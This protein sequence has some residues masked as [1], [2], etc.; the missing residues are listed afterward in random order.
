MKA[1]VKLADVPREAQVLLWTA[2][3]MTRLAKAGAISY[4][5]AEIGVD[6]LQVV[7]DL[8]SVKPTPAELL[9]ACRE[10]LGP[11][12]DPIVGT[13]NFYVYGLLCAVL[14]V[15]DVME[16]LIAKSIRARRKA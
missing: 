3:K 10:I 6:S 9:M 7:D 12:D 15:P 1:P 16:P 14:S 13:D 11:A 2:H 8:D 4:T 5:P